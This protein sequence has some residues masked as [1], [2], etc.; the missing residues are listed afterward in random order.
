MMTVFKWL[1]IALAAIIVVIGLVLGGMRFSDGPK[2]I[3]AG[4]P[5]KT[6][7][8]ADTPDDWNFLKGR[9]EIEFQTIAPSTS[10]IVWLAV[11]DGRLFIVSGYMNT[12]YGKIWKQWPTYLAEDDRIILRIDGKLYE[13]R[14]ER[15]LEF[16]DLVEL[17]GIFKAKYG[18]EIATEVSAAALDEGLKNGDFWLFEVVERQE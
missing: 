17:M 4:G 10:R 13:Q 18:V 1:G 8:Y 9:P 12:N 6:G 7:E 16:S 5:F 15:L 14:L 3:L 11:I 2:A